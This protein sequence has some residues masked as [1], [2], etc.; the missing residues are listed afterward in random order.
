MATPIEWLS[1]TQVNSVPIVAGFDAQPKILGLAT[2]GYVVAWV[3]GSPGAIETELGSAIIAKI[4][5][6][7]GNVVRDSF[8][9]SGISA[10]DES[11]FDLAATHDGFA[12]SYIDESS[13]FPDFTRV[14]YERYDLDGDQIFS[15]IIKTENVSPDYLRDP[16]LAVNLTPS[17]DDAFI[18]Y[19]E[20][21]AGDIDINARVIGQD[22]NLNPEFGAAQNSADFDRLGD[23]AVLSNGNFVTAYIEN[24]PG[25]TSIEFSIRTSS[26]TNVVIAQTAALSGDDVQV[27]SLDGGGF[28]VVYED[29]DDIFAKTFDNNGTQTGG[30]ITVA[31]AGADKSE[32]VVRALPD[33]G[34]VVM[35][36]VE[37]QDMILARRYD[38][39]GTANGTTFTV[40]NVAPSRPVDI[41]VSADGRILF[42]WNSPAGD[43]FTSIWDPRDSV[44]NTDDYNGELASKANFLETNVVTTGTGNTTVFGGV[45]KDTVLGQAGDDRILGFGGDDNL[46]GGAGDDTLNGGDGNDTIDA[47][48]G[49]D[50]VFAEAGDDI[51]DGGAGNDL[52]EGKIGDDTLNGGDG[53]DILRGSDGEDLIIGG[54]GDDI[55]F[56][57][58]GKDRLGGGDGNDTLD[59]SGGDD[60]ILG[61]DG[62]DKLIGETGDDELFGG[63]GNDI[64]RGGGGDDLLIGDDGDDLMFGSS[65]EDKIE[66]G[67]GDDILEGNAQADE[68]FG[69]DGN[70]ILRGGDGFDRLEGGFD[71]DILNGGNGEDVLNGGLGVDILRGNAQDDTFLFESTQDSTFAAS[72]LIE[73][74]EGIGV[75]GGDVIDVSDID[76]IVGNFSHSDSFQFLGLQTT[77]NALSSGPGVLWVE[78]VGTQ[79]RLYGNTDGDNDIEFAVRIQDGVGI[80][81]ADYVEGDFFL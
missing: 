57:G 51:V 45:K 6:A 23:V 25:G 62:D 39:D 73:G 9:L 14:R 7:E 35:W 68:L 31:S 30:L 61:A 60:V 66:G 74:I 54:D 11:D 79:T 37:S 53:D 77:A 1:E 38:S 22:N 46:S 56:G 28:V 59:G 19:E 21:S 47:G 29:N 27:S 17:N 5:D 48:D 10:G 58:N 36:K 8:R 26:G 65:G 20:F 70:D 75:A 76:A 80:S 18:A 63:D 49:D 13:V 72:D 33:D 4:Y 52:L 78:D 2:G 81:A 50:R 15:D 64:L 41:D 43:V 44:L 42:A 24:D 16:Q 40:A 71:D 32:P 55:A 3:E 67:S 69:D 12:M 34:F